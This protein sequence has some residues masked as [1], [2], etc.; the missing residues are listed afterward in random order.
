VSKVCA[1]DPSC[2]NTAWNSKCIQEVWTVAQ[3]P[4]C[5]PP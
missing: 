4:E 2:C 1:A 3:S 5:G